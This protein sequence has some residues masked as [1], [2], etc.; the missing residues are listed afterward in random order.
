MKTNEVIIL[1]GGRGTRL[2]SLTNDQPKPMLKV[3]GKPFLEILLDYLI[4]QNIG[5]VILS[6]G[7]HHDKIIQHFKYEYKSLNIQYSIEEKPL[8]TG[9]AILHSLKEI[10]NEN[11]FVMNG[12]TL[13]NIDLKKLLSIHMLK[14]VS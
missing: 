10:S 6:V 5:K 3:A 9:G 1:A 11:F 14:K 2:K 13:F 12:D 4:S 7:Y 8:G